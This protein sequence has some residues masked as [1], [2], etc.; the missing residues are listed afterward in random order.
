MTVG[1]DAMASK[2]CRLPKDIRLTETVVITEESERDSLPNYI[3]VPCISLLSSFIS[4]MM[5]VFQR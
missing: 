1:D 4:V 2:S 5:P 3:A